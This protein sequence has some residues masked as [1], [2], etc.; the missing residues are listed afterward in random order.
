MKNFIFIFFCVFLFLTVAY[1]QDDA[2]NAEVDHLA[3]ATLMIYDGRLDKAEA[4]LAH[5]DTASEAF[6][7]ARYYTVSGV[8]ASK[9][10][11]YETAIENYL[12]AID[13]TKAKTFAP[14]NVEE[15]RKYLFSLG[16]SETENA[17][18][19][20]PAFDG[21]KIKKEK[22]DK[23][24]IYLSQAYY[25]VKDYANTVKHLDLAGERGRNRAALFSLRAEC[26]WKI[27]QFN[28]AI[29]ALN[30]GLALFPDDAALLKQKYYSFADLGLYQ[31]AVKCARHYMRVIQADAEE[32][33]IL[34]QL[35]IEVEQE[36]EAIKI[37][38]TA[39][40]KFPENAKIIMLLGHIYMEKGK[41]F[42]AARLFKD[43]A[44]LDKKYL[45]DAVEMHRRIKDFSHAI[46]LNTQMADKM[47]KLRQKVA[48]YLDRGEFE[49]VI[50][51]TDGLERYNLLEDDNLRYALAYSYYMAKDYPNA[52]FHLKKIYDN[53]LFAKGTVILR[54]IEKCR[55]N[56]T[57]C[58]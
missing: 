48:I 18:P 42:T 9:K 21:E 41:N 49:K 52:E 55:Q 45:K 14:P 16:N 46:Y 36:D 22:L 4:E 51:L 29:S 39:K 53:A 10:E 11:A 26:Y 7:A 19:P 15:K 56:S 43:A 54:N 3:L 20:V 25:K 2:E 30:K 13:A 27:E 28:E 50:G 6:D 24:H 44:Y 12:L 57:E 47:E 58:F 35:L 17:S 31:S 38:E 40:G 37:L 34:A 5:V 33:I 23:L 8:L 32:Y 1:A